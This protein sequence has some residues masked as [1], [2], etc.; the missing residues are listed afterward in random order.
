MASTDQAAKPVFCGIFGASVL[1]YD[2]FGG[3]S[4]A[5]TETMIDARHF[6]VDISRAVNGTLR[7]PELS[8]DQK[9]WHL[10][11]LLA[12]AFDVRT[13]GQAA[14]GRY[15]R[16]AATWQREDY[17]SAFEAYAID[18][19]ARRLAEFARIDIE[20]GG[21]KVLNRND[22]LVASRICEPRF[23]RPLPIDWRVRNTDGIFQ[24]V[25]V[26]VDGTS[27]VATRRAEF[28]AIIR[29]GGG[30]LDALL[31]VLGDKSA[32]Q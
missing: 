29:Q 6:I 8:Q 2:L 18:L 12:H 21:T 17:V 26:V 30:S 15:W 5:A 3:S 4:R 31:D 27:L 1:L 25:D 32:S 16:K 24:I 22:V 23:G 28:R 20:I 13:L 7:N 19:S 11:S 10:R 9:I 14:L